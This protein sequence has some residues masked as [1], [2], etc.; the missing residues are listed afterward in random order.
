MPGRA[1]PPLTDDLLQ[2]ILTRSVQISFFSFV[3]P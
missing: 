2:D 3:V 1:E